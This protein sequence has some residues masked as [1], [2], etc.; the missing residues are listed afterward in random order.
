MH[1]TTLSLGRMFLEIIIIATNRYQYVKSSEQ[2]II[3]LF[4]LC[5]VT[6][7]RTGIFLTGQLTDCTFLEW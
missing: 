7:S 4:H 2:S 3:F 5:F 1:S 6:M